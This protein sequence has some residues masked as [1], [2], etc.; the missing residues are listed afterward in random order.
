MRWPS[1]E[2]RGTT[3]TRMWRRISRMRVVSNT[4]PLTNLAVIGRLEWVREEFGDGD[5]PGGGLARGFGAGTRGGKPSGARGE[6]S[7]LDLCRAG[8][9]PR[10][11]PE[12][13][14]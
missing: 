7:R 10:T 11:G 4:S 13:F 9:E 5:G 1:G 6:E 12:S 14:D 8:G 2:F 3:R